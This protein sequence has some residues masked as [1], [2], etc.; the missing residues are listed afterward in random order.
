MKIKV[1]KNNDEVRFVDSRDGR[2]IFNQGSLSVA[3]TLKSE[4]VT[5]GVRYNGCSPYEDH[6]DPLILTSSNANALLS[7]KLKAKVE[8]EDVENGVV[9]SLDCESELISELGLNLP[10]DFMGK[11][12]SDHYMHQYLFS[13]PY[14]SEDERYKYC[15]LEK[16]D[17]NNLFVLFLSEA[18]G[19]KMDYSP[20]VGGHYFVNLQILANFDRAY[21][22][23]SA[24]TKLKIALL[25]VSSIEE[26]VNLATKMLH[27]PAAI[28]RLSYTFDGT[29]KIEVVGHCD[30]AV[31]KYDNGETAVVFPENG[32]VTIHNACRKTYV[33]PFFGQ[34]QGMDCS[35][36]GY[37]DL[38]KEWEKVAEHIAT[39]GLFP[40]KDNACEGS[41]Y[42]STLLRFML[43][44]GRRK[45]M[46]KIISEFMETFLTTDESK[47][48]TRLTIFDK[49]QNG[50][51][52]YHEYNACRIQ[53]QMFGI[54]ILLDAYRLYGDERYYTY[55]VNALNTI[56]DTYQKEDG[57]IET[58]HIGKMEDYSTV[59]CLIIPIVDMS[60][61]VK[62]RDPA[63]SERY[64]KAAKS[65]ASY[66]N[67]RGFHLPT[68]GGDTDLAEEQMEDGS[69]SC[70][71]LSLLYYCARIEVV[72]EFVEM[73]KK[74]LDF[75]ETW[76]MKTFDCN[77]YRSSLRW[78]ETRWEGDEDGPA[79]CCGHGWTIWRAEADY[80]Y[81]V[82]T[83]DQK[84][85]SN[86]LSSFTSNFAKVDK[87]GRER[88]IYQMDYITGGGFSEKDGIRYEIA[89]RFPR[90]EDRSTSYYV[91]IRAA[92]TILK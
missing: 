68:E 74:I 62:D 66:I 28:Y 23:G 40:T 17:G 25:A 35:I 83:G 73:A 14:R 13:S 6:S 10:L 32:K 20:Y 75:H 49:P 92:E 55:A 15:Y 30:K 41:C 12:G 89:P 39:S 88:A 78:W 9:V 86:A 26:G 90:K 54:T 70:S 1:I 37:G 87:E 21:G 51:P 63:L 64:R 2:C 24:R 45:E 31:V 43:K 36:W 85:L 65:L 44:H 4:D 38:D 79:L 82:I 47:A 61:F 58:P 57:R 80:W 56:L 59:C 91:W 81:Y 11:T 48:V 34:T 7:K 60:L 18:D 77:V 84:A 27:V 52:A 69:I 19:W 16:P 5:K 50:Y 71:A 72:P 76:M 3:Y 53:E 67:N 46:D 33:I 8:L 42:V 22:T 29:A